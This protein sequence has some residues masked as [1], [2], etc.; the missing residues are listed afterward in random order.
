MRARRI[1]KQCNF[2]VPVFCLAFHKILTATKPKWWLN[3][4][5]NEME[6]VC[7]FSANIK[8]ISL[9]AAAAPR[10]FCPRNEIEGPPG[11]NG[12]VSERHG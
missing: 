5:V 4:C 1:D 12:F 2:P 11:T 6:P 7:L 10:K 8:A 3:V 9:V